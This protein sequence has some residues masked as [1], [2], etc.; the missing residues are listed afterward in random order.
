MNLEASF[1]S[2]AAAA[3]AEGPELAHCEPFRVG[4]IE[5]VPARRELRGPNDASRTIQPLAM[6]VLLA[7]AEM[8]PGT[9]SRDDLI[10][11]CWSQRIVGDD[12]I[13]RVISTLRRD[14]TTLSGGAVGIETIAKVGYRLS[15]PDPASEIAAKAR[16]RLADR[17]ASL[18]SAL[19]PASAFGLAAAALLAMELSPP[20]KP[21][22]FTIGVEP[23]TNTANDRQ[24]RRFAAE[25]GSDLV[26][27]AGAAS[28]V[29][30]IDPAVAD[31]AGTADILVRVSVER[32]GAGLAARARLVDARDGAI[33]LARD[34][35][36]EDGNLA[37]LR[38]RTAAGLAGAITCGLERSAGIYD[39][40]ATRRLYFAA[41][42]AIE[43]EDMSQA[44]VLTRQL[45]ARRPDVAA[46]WACLAQSSLQAGEEDPARLA[47]ARR[48]AERAIRLDPTSGRGYAALALT[49][50]HND[51]RVIATLERGLRAD[52]EHVG[53]YAVYATSL[54]NAGYVED[55]VV[56]AQRA[57]AL[58][59]ASRFRYSL[60]VRRLLAVGR[61]QEALAVHDQ[62]ERLF[63]GSPDILEHRLRLLLY[64]PN[65]KEALAEFER[66]KAASHAL[67][68][69]PLAEAELRW[70][71]DP[72]SIDLAE[73]DRMAEAEFA[74]YPPAAW[75]I[76]A[77]MARLGQTERAWAWLARAPRREASNQWSL[78]FWPEVAPLR[79]DPRFFAA[80]AE[81]GL[82]RIWTYRGKWPDFCAEP[83]LRYSCAGE[84]RRLGHAIAKS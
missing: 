16:V 72:N 70:R 39:D 59:P 8:H 65:P 35:S 71:A 45:V 14:L 6:R 69:G 20:S 43:S 30:F 83:D 15:F 55:S 80:M 38:D 61:P 78:L 66:A 33:I 5:V 54:F 60:L 79:Q 34:F 7:L 81:L 64:R 77:T 23:V 68:S 9:C 22:S 19:L 50:G 10:R 13:H 42:D 51:P 21:D 24:A 37:R 47:A 32:D 11:S 49:W 1:A 63:P 52:P 31:S 73:L 26:R 48:Y 67:P 76:A 27:F 25:V 28:R 12:A 57:L 44:E 58:N 4:P 46:G 41:C 29:N 62:A 40:L 75:S 53:L 84:A 3:G 17:L 74:D 18:R 56:P 82:V 2:I 36:D